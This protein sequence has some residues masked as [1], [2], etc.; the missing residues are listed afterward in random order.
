MNERHDLKGVRAGG[1]WLGGSKNRLKFKRR[2][3]KKK[4]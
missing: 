3:K 1:E 2:D 4:G